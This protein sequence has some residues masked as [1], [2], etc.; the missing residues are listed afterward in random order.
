MQ[1]CKIPVWFFVIG[2]VKVSTAVVLF[3]VFLYVV[4]RKKLFLDKWISLA[5]IVSGLVLYYVMQLTV[6]QNTFNIQWG[7]FYKVF[8]N[9]S[10]PIYFLLQY[11][12]RCSYVFR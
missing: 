3:I 6:V 11:D 7:S 8:V 2:Y 5:A 12:C 1:N 10:I 4:L 9:G